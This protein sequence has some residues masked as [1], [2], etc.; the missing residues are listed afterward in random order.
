MSDKDRVAEL[1]RLLEE[2]TRKHERFREEDRRKDQKSTLSE[3]LYNCH[4]HIYVKLRLPPP[5]HGLPVPTTPV[6]DLWNF[7][8]F[9]IEQPV[10]KILAPIWDDKG[11]R[12]R[13]PFADIRVKSVGEMPGFGEHII[14]RETRPYGFGIQTSLDGSEHYAFVFDY[15]HEYVL[16]VEHLQE[17]HQMETLFEDVNTRAWQEYIA[18]VLIRVFNF[19]II[20]GVS[21]GYVAAGKFHDFLYYDPT[22]PRTLYHHLFVPENV[23]RD[24]ASEDDW[25]THMSNTAVAQL[26]S[27]CLQSL[28]SEAAEGPDLER[29][30]M[31]RR[32]HWPY[33]VCLIGLKTGRDLANNCPNVKFRRAVGK[34]EQHQ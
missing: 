28:Q 21:Y 9:A 16:S 1:E 19:M 20:Y 31:L 25:S 29:R 2:V 23:V 15:Q 30:R 22:E 11:L 12:G 10:G 7:E 6:D 17:A 18:R 34:N 5:G 27:F 32:N 8:R 3:C 24:A 13:Y 26:A 14:A 4:F 33:G